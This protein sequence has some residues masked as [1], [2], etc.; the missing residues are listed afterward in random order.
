[1]HVPHSGRAGT[2]LRLKAGMALTVEPMINLGSPEIRI[3][4]DGWTVVTSD[5]K[6]SAQFEHT[7]LVTKNG[8]EILTL[9]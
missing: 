8:Y 7:V 2:G 4:D 1:P 6:W 3:L 5:G 9:V